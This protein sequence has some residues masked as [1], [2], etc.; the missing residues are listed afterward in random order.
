MATDYKIILPL[1]FYGEK[2]VPGHKK[3]LF[4]IC[5]RLR[6]S[7]NSVEILYCEK[8]KI[9]DFEGHCIPVSL[10]KIIQNKAFIESAIIIGPA[11]DFRPTLFMKKHREIKYYVADSILKTSIYAFLN[12]Y[13]L[14]HRVLYAFLIEILLRRFEIIVASLEEYTWFSSSGHNYDQLYLITPLPDL[15]T[16]SRASEIND[17]CKK[18]LFY[19]PWGGGVSFAGKLIKKFIDL[20]IGVDILITGNA[21]DILENELP[22]KHFI[23][24]TRFVDN[25]SALIRSCSLVVI[26]DMS[27]S[28]FCNRAMQVRGLGVPLLCT[29]PSLRGTGLILDSNVHILYS[30]AQGFE[31]IKNNIN[32]L[33]HEDSTLVEKII[34]NAH[35]SID[36][37]SQEEPRKQENEI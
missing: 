22:R 14:F 13:L 24:Y 2:L 3:D 8:N 33:K 27:G 15:S 12:N 35:R 1:S 19:N 28:G 18:I 9:Y 31:F 30:P 26:T 17:C 36:Y 37:F 32:E 10:V 5:D 25:I 16:L 6:S 4:K 11:H 34:I 21:A 23:R 20:E 29:L 7:G